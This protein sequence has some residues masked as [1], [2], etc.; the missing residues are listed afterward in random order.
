MADQSPLQPW[1]LGGQPGRRDEREAG[2]NEDK[3]EPERTAGAQ[4]HRW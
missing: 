4:L 3:L 1:A 2:E